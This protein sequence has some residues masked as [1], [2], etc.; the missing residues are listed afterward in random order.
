MKCLE[1]DCEVSNPSEILISYKDEE[2]GAS[3]CFY[4]GRHAPHAEIQSL[5]APQFDEHLNAAQLVITKRLNMILA[6][7]EK[8]LVSV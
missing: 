1:A 7:L 5:S 4:P 6:V 3:Y 2:S 8:E